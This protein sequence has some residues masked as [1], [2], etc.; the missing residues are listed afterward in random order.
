MF[1]VHVL[2]TTCVTS[3]Y[4]FYSIFGLD[5]QVD[6]SFFSVILLKCKKIPIGLLIL[7]SIFCSRG[8]YVNGFSFI[9]GFEKIFIKTVW[10][11][12]TECH[13]QTFFAHLARLSSKSIKVIH[14]NFCQIVYT[15]LSLVEHKTSFKS[16]IAQ[17]PYPESKLQ[18]QHQICFLF[19]QSEQKLHSILCDVKP[20]IYG[21]CGKDRKESKKECCVFHLHA[22]II[23][24][25]GMKRK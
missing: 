10:K 22:D 16:N 1:Q 24:A 15:F 2:R 5:F 6:E 23:I 9:G 14:S 18:L 19:K 11:G 4:F 13:L 20:G 8:F 25:R 7:G 21:I 17:C 3:T 12:V